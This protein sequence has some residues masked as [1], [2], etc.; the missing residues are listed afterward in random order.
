[1]PEPIPWTFK[2][3]IANFQGVD[4]PIGDFA[5]DILSDPD[6][7][8]EDFF[9]EIYDHLRRKKLHPE[10]LEEFLSIW[11]FYCCSK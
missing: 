5:A 3:W 6:F 2:E 11:N 8:D 4:L 10:Q 1:M 9:P 7:P